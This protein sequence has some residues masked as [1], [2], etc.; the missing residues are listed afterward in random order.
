MLK[1]L[2]RVL[3]GGSSVGLSAGP[4]ESSPEPTVPLPD[5]GRSEKQR[6][7]IP[8]ISQDARARQVAGNTDFAFDLYRE[9][10]PTSPNLFF[11]PFSISQTLAMAYAG[12]RGETESQ[13][14]S[15]LHFTGRQEDVHS[16]FNW[17]N[18]HLM[19]GA[20]TPAGAPEN[21]FKVSVA[22][23]IWGRSG[24]PFEAAFLA[25]LARHHGSDLKTLDFMGAPEDSRAIINDW[26]EK[27]TNGRI[28]D[29]IPPGS[30]NQETRMILT[31]AIYFKASW[32][33][34]FNKAST[35]RGDFFRRDGTRARADL[36]FQM[37][38]FN[39]AQMNGFQAVELPYTRDISMLVL[40][41]EAL[42]LFEQNLSAATLRET[43]DA[44]KM[45]EV[46]LTLPKFEFTIPLMLSGALRNLGMTRAF[47][48]QDADFSGM[49]DPSDLFIGAVLH[50]AFIAVDEE[51]TEAAAATAIIMP[52][53]CAPSPLNK[54][55]VFKADKP[56]VFVIRDNTTQS[57]L[58]VGRVQEPK[59][60]S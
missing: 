44:L 53:Q 20:K 60:A 58:F 15:A 28:K 43:V 17:L 29:L 30:I 38:T 54:P 32:L 21:S 18:A 14:A 33:Q 42:D 6:V 31:N 36:M 22:N 10:A 8:N 49:T 57:L 27:N 25:T 7:A 50:Q 52:R 5:E 23:S 12:A 13:M 46:Q 4:V 51:I 34:P 39:Y 41:P 11:S 19:G 26:V 55:I 48:S 1:S 59:A 56:F 40:L 2:F 37:S 16:A 35:K 3:F 24:Y 9:I 45:K 47:D